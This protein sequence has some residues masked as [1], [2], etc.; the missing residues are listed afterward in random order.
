MKDKEERRKDEKENNRELGEAGEGVTLRSRRMP[1]CKGDVEEKSQ[2]GRDP[3]ENIRAEEAASAKAR[4]QGE[5][6]MLGER[7]GV[8]CG[9][10]QV[11]KGRAAGDV[12]T[13]E[14]GATGP[15]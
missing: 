5:T 13:E 10:I 11:S 9:S 12:V 3:E 8:P 6:G 1:L 15:P 4:R 14:A 2:P 7:K